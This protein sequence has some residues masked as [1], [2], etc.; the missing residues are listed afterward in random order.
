MKREN[1]LFISETNPEFKRGRQRTRKWQIFT[2]K[3]VH[4]GKLLTKN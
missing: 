4:N 3:S 2:P 1:K